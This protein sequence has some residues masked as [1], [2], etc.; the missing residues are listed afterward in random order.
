ME[1]NKDIIISCPRMLY[2]LMCLHED[3]IFQ[4]THFA[5]I[6]DYLEAA[7]TG[8]SCRKKV[9][10]DKAIELYKV[11][12]IKVRKDIISNFKLALGANNLLFF[13]DNHHLFTV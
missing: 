6:K 7:Y 13:L 1:E 4:D 10:E 12:N 2:D 5:T 3:I 11:V 9:N 8:C